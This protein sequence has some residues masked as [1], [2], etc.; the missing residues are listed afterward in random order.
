MSRRTTLALSFLLGVFGSLKA[1][2]NIAGQITAEVVHDTVTGNCSNYLYYKVTVTTYTNSLSPADRCDLTIDWGDNTSSTVHRS[3]GIT[4]SCPNATMGVD[5]SSQGFANTKENVYVG[6]HAFPGAGTYHIS[7]KDPNRVAGILNIPNSVNVPFYLETTITIDPLFGCNS[8]PYLTTIPLDKACTGHC[9]YHN[10]GAVDPDGD[11]LSYSIGPCL[12]TT[13]LPIAGYSLPNV[14]GG[15]SLAIDPV[16]GDL[17]WCSPGVAGKYNLVIYITEWKRLPNGNHVKI[18]TVLRDMS[19]DVQNNCNNNNPDISNLQDLCVDAGTLVNFNL[20]VDDPDGDSVKL[21]GYGSP[22]SSSPAASVVPSATYTAVPYNA[23]FNWQTTCNNVRVQPWTA[24]FKATDNHSPV[25]LTD[26]E[27][28]NITVVSPGPAFL[29]TTPQGSQ[30]NLSWGQ[31]P[32]DPL[33]NPCIGYKVYRR[34]GPTSWMHAQCETGVPAY[35]GF[36]QIGTVTGVNNTTFVDDNNGSGLVPGVDYCYRVCA[37]F[38]D[39]AE[40]Y[41]SPE[42]CNELRR[43]VPVIVNVDIM[44]TGLSDSVYVRWV[45]ALANGIDFDTTQHVGPYIL[46]LERSAGYSLSSPATIATFTVNS[47]YQLPT[48]FIDTLRQTSQTPYTY[49][50]KFYGSGGSDYI[51]NSQPASSTYAGAMPSDNTV[52]LTWQDSV[53]WN[54]FEYAI[55]RLNNVTGQ[56]DS[57]TTVASHTYADDSLEN[58][59]DYCYYV[60]A[61]GSYFNPTLPPI[62]YNRSQR[63]CATPVDL[64]PPCPPQLAVNSDCSTAVNQLTWTNP[65][66]MNCGTDDVVL[67]HIYYAAVEGDPFELISTVTVPADTTITYS[68]LASVAGCYAVTAV[69]TFG[70]ES[71]YSDIV[72]VDN[73]PVYMLPNV[74]TPNGDNVNDFFI[75]FPYQYVKDIDLKIYDRWGNLIFETTD[76]DIN[77]DGRDMKSH[78]LCTDGVYYYTC[79]VNEI[80]LQG[81]VPRQLTGFVHLFGKDVGQFH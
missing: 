54:N 80:R 24:T 30:M 65:I 49:R 51:G 23:N 78:K 67:Y 44:S 64:T 21:Q 76:P 37:F 70:N 3:N 28:V 81:I 68:N 6:F 19:I 20:T 4:G 60:K 56:W 79:T 12:D 73:C 58:G 43:D 11:S 69:D 27:S 17:S 62:Q 26:I 75:P 39:G 13:G 7:V 36:V 16:T 71:A 53:P 35:T 5:L 29:T 40:S 38:L 8:T 31:N 32:C 42:S 47:F 55:Y 46:E 10:P 25:A 41:S 59:I 57:L 22:F 72:C 74:F 2:H 14:I 45:N 50:L 52:T 1:T 33:V 34:Q 66:N 77:W 61:H 48:V 18:G 15:G 9:Y 63:V